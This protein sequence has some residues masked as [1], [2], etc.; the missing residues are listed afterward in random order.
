MLVAFLEGAFKSKTICFLTYRGISRADCH[1]NTNSICVLALKYSW[2]SGGV[3]CTIVVAHILRRWQHNVECCI[4]SNQALLD[5]EMEKLCV[6]CFYLLALFRLTHN[7]L[8]LWKN[9]GAM[10]PASQSTYLTKICDFSTLFKT[11][12]CFRPEL[13]L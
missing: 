1:E 9:T 7:T 8:N 11:W 3:I 10:R 6:K 4:Y 5:T 13:V 12:P 2:E